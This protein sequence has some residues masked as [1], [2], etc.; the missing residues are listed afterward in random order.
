MSGARRSLFAAEARAQLTR[1][2]PERPAERRAML[3][4]VVLAGG[5]VVEAGG[6]RELVLRSES[7]AVARVAL[8]LLRDVDAH[9]RVRRPRAGGAA[10][11]E[12]RAAGPAVE[13]LLRRCG[14]GGAASGRARGRPASLRRLLRTRSARRAFLRGLFLGSGSVND[15]GRSLHLEIVLPDEAAALALKEAAADFG[16]AF[17]TGRRKSA[18]RA[19][20]KSAGEIAEFLRVVGADPS[21]LAFEGARTRR[22]MRNRVNRLVNADTA[23]MRKAANA[24]A[25]QIEAI[26]ALVAARGWD[27]IPRRLAAVARLRLEY[28]EASLAELG[29]M[30]EPP[31]GKSGVRYRMDRLLAL[32]EAIS[33]QAKQ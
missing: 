11:I 4:G 3:A 31:L 17:R 12:V 2:G 18:L 28:P 21:L 26:R 5:R 30:M 22:E 16:L 27:G 32:E 8:D 13:A 20:L 15:P 25:R 10:R 33:R 29:S 14:R 24:A 9:A 19:Y 6:R 1:R 7:P 23:N